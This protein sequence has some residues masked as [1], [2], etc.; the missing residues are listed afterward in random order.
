[1]NV[2]PGIQPLY[3]LVNVLHEQLNQLYLLTVHLYHQSDKHQYVDPYLQFRFQYCHQLPVKQKQKQKMCD[4]AHL[5]QT[6]R[7]LQGGEPR[8]QPLGNQKHSHHLLEM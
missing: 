2:R 3:L 4:G 7:S 8:F 6:V 1:M 5:N